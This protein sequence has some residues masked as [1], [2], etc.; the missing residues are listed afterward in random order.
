MYAGESL[1]WLGVALTRPSWR[2]LALFACL[3][4][5]MGLRVWWEERLISGYAAYRSQT[6]WRFVPGIW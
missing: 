1:T 4:A 3:L 2:N 6:P 5:I